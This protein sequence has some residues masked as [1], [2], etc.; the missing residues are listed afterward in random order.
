MKVLIVDDNTGMR[1]LLRRA[2]PD[3]VSAIFECSD[4]ADA[5]AV[6]AER[7]P[8]VVLMDIRM[9]RMDGLAAARKIRDFDRAAR[10]VIVTDYDDEDLRAAAREAGACGYALK[11]NLIELPAL[12]RS[13]RKD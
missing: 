11:E 12:I 9:P 2:V 6:Y 13:F 7:Q 4:G 5:L 10:V 1:R 8:D 3:I